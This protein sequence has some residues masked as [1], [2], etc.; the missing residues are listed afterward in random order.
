MLPDE[1][2]NFVGDPNETAYR[3]SIV[4]EP[5]PEAIV[6]LDVLQDF[7]VGPTAEGYDFTQSCFTTTAG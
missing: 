1:A 6:G 2:G 5:N 3:G 7:F 4:S